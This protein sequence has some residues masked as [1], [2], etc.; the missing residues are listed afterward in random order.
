MMDVQL[1]ELIDKIKSEGIKSAEQESAR[2]LKEAENKANDIIAAAHKE[3]SAI[4]AKGKD[5]TRRFEQTAKEAVQQAGR[6]TILSLRT[7]ITEFF[8]SLI[9]AETKEAYTPKVLEEAVT[10]LVKAWS[11]EQV[12]DL[13]IL[14]SAEDLKKIEK[15]LKSRL[16]AELKK[17]A[18]LKPFP[19]I[20][21]GFRIAVKD[22]SAY[23]NFT[24]QGIAEI[25]AEYLNP[26]IAEIVREAAKKEK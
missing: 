1:Q 20:Q 16:S 25:L 21:A 18:E 19:E 11:K 9:A 5:E 12:S 3:A 10:S 17:G 22:G 8:D 13:Q 14:L 6:N 26:K 15:Q 23:Y 4:I 7:R 24:D 2:V